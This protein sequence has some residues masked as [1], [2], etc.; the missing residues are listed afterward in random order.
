MSVIWMTLFSN[1]LTFIFFF[2]LESEKKMIPK[3]EKEFKYNNYKSCFL[4]LIALYYQTEN[5]TEF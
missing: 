4:L 1:K 5:S 2:S 3:K